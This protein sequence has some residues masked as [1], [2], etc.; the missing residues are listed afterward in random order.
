MSTMLVPAD[1]LQ[2]TCALG[3]GI[4]LWLSA[5]ATLIIAA[6]AVPVRERPSRHGTPQ[7][8]FKGPL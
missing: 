6:T 1:H 3:T 5:F 2:G 7:R 8:T 4:L